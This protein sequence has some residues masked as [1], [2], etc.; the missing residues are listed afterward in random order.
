MSI[1]KRY[2][3]LSMN[4]KIIISILL[5][6][7]LGA[8][9]G[10]RCKVLDSVNSAFVGAL[11]ITIIPYLFFSLIRSIGSLSNKTAADAAKY[12]GWI[13]LLLWLVSAIFAWF[14]PY[15][16][17]AIDRATFFVPHV[18]GTGVAKNI[19]LVD[20]F[21][22]SNPFHALAEG[23]IPAVVLFCILMGTSLINAKDK[24]ESL[25]LL[26]KIVVSLKHCNDYIMKIMPFGLMLIAA[27]TF[28]V[29]SPDGAQEILLYVTASI[30][31]NT[32]FTLLVLPALA[33][34]FTQLTYKQIIRAAAP[35]L[36]L[37]FASGNSFMSLPL[38]YE[39]L[40]ALDKEL[41][42]KKQLSAEVIEERRKHIDVFVPL[43]FIV[44]SSYKFLVI[45][46]V[47]FGGW[48]FNV[49]ITFPHQL[50]LFFVGVPCLFGSNVLV[51]PF[52]LKLVHIPSQAFD[53][54]FIT[55][56][57]LV[58]FNNAN[59][60]MFIVVIVLMWCAAINRDWHFRP[61]KFLIFTPLA[62]MLSVVCGLSLYFGF[63]YLINNSESKTTGVLSAD[64][65]PP[66]R[67]RFSAIA[68]VVEPNASALK[69]FAPRS[70][71]ADF[72]QQILDSRELRVGYIPNLPFSFTNKKGKLVGLD[73]NLIYNLAESLDCKKIIFFPLTKS[74]LPLVNDGALDIVVG[75][76]SVSEAHLERY[77]MS[78]PYINLHIAIMV[79][80]NK[81]EQFPDWDKTL[82]R[83]SRDHNL[84]IAVLS[85]AYVKSV[86]HLFPNHKTIVLQQKS[87]FFE[88]NPADLMFIS[89]E[90]GYSQRILHPQYSVYTAANNDNEFPAAFPLPSEA[91][92]DGWR[93][94][95]N[96]W[97]EFKRINGYVTRNYNYW[98]SGIGLE[99]KQARWSILTE[100]EER[101]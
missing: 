72:L 62:I 41:A 63:S 3:S 8:F 39:G 92:A 70:A 28:G 35:A 85:S 48:F 67:Q 29:F 66:D 11:Q 95:V 50:L 49:A 43:A 27:Y 81:K 51:V 94:F 69:K 13:L 97:I 91:S 58:F 21:I 87:E 34:I 55:S 38:A 57:I 7:A 84:S 96:Q 15:C 86:K 20:V 17:P 30:V 37:S 60:T 44:P 83:L 46:F 68:A 24:L 31:Y 59:N 74:E 64:F 99:Q 25:R 82:E 73:V 22:P 19:N 45:F 9:F 101:F 4:K 14:L 65:L 71:N 93:A 1:A 89:A 10:E 16:F 52:L 26:D 75:G 36:L 40:Y 100:L 47:M 2:Q 42:E 80:N 54:F 5:G 56:N 98:I 90:E 32:I 77:K 53:I 79:A 18:P 78:I 88:K 6:V 76:I 61:A 33:I 12:C 23:Y